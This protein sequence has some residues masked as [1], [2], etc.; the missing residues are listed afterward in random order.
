MHNSRTG[1]QMPLKSSLLD[2]LDSHP[3]RLDI[4]AK[5]VAVKQPWL[6]THG[7]VDPTVP[8][9]HAQELHEAQPN[10]KFIIFPG[11]DHTFGG[12]HPYTGDTLPASLLEFCDKAISFLRG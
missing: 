12:S 2:D 4:Q 8:L 3:L 11:G 9:A 6:L 1:Q 5:A 10:A 7:D